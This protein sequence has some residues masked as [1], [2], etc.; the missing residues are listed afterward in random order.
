MLYDDGRIACGETGMTI[1]GYYFPW[2]SKRIPYGAI[3]SVRRL[4]PGAG[5]LRIWGSGDFVHWWNLDPGRPKK[6][7]AFEIDTGGR[8]RP[9][10]TPDDPEELAQILDERVVARG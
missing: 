4:P 7:V 1:R 8:I 3:H 5:R 10:I 2:G 9:A 6:A